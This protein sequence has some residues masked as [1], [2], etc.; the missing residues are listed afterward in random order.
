MDIPLLN[1]LSGIFTG[2][3]TGLFITKYFRNKDLKR[4]IIKYADNTADHTYDI[5][6]EALD[7]INGIGNISRLKILLRKPMR[8]DFL[9]GINDSDLQSAIA[10]CNNAINTI[11]SIF[12]EEENEKEEVIRPKLIGPADEMNLPILNLWNAIAIYKVNE[13]NK[14]K[15]END[16]FAAT[17]LAIIFLIWALCEIYKYI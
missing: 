9:G 1:I 8:R 15:R 4:K 7:Y 10:Q 14:E 13:R 6:S 11:S 5:M 12:D 3:I 17:I 2:L 16:Y